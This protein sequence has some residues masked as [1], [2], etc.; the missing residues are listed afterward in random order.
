[1]DDEKEIRTSLNK[2]LRRLG[3]FHVALAGT[4]EEALQELVKYIHYFG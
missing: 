4:A 2:V 1:V 3:G